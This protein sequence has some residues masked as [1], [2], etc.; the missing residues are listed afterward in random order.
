MVTGTFKGPPAN[1]IAPNLCQNPCAHA[2]TVVFP[3]Q[4]YFQIFFNR[5]EQFTKTCPIR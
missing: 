3:C 1:H 5:L 2:A 4:Q